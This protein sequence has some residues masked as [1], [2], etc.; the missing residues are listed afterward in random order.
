MIGLGLFFC[1]ILPALAWY[2]EPFVDYVC[3]RSD[4]KKIDQQLCTKEA[5]CSPIAQ[6]MDDQYLPVEV[7]LTGSTGSIAYS[8][9]P[10]I[11]RGEM[12]GPMQQVLLH[13]IVRDPSASN[14]QGLKMELDDGA[15]PLLSGVRIVDEKNESE[16]I[17]TFRRAHA[18]ILLG[19]SPRK[20]GME[21]KDLMK[22][23]VSI[24]KTLGERLEKSHNK[25]AR[26]LVVGNPANTNAWTLANSAPSIPRENFSALTR[27]DHNRARGILL[28]EARSAFSALDR[29]SSKNCDTCPK[30]TTAGQINGVIIWGNHSA[31]QYPDYTHVGFEMFFE[32]KATP[33]KK[34][35][36]MKRVKAIAAK[37]RTRGSAV[38]KAR[39]NSSAASC[40]IAIVDHMRD[41]VMGTATKSE[42]VSMAVFGNAGSPA[43]GISP[44]IV[45]S[46]PMICTANVPGN[47]KCKIRMGLKI[48]AES[49]QELD[50]NM[51]ELIDEKKMAMDIVTK[52]S[53]RRPR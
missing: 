22:A 32:T 21:R 12:F 53:S 14:L 7:V 18:I 31:T 39:G 42:M 37:V 26:I 2:Q 24:F 9:L 47:G 44:D 40:A 11:M 49:R 10:M 52:S 15:F 51:K 50:K 27:L 36:D 28:S 20:A 35:L 43:Y 13:L 4:V 25:H 23:N 33:L 34:I 5:K 16:V 3:S 45:Y 46:Y 17:R 19:S 1:G 6:I 38:L 41:W 8:L 48:D 30:Y 29:K